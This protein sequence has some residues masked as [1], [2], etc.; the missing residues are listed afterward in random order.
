[1]LWNFRNTNIFVLFKILIISTIF[2][3]FYVLCV[4]QIY[5]CCHCSFFIK[6]I[7]SL[8]IYFLNIHIYY[9]LTY[10]LMWA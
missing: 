1:M 9:L 2:L 5:N 3:S 8:K 10:L 7:I 4:F 6:F